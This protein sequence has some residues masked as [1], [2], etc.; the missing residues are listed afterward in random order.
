M[1]TTTTAIFRMLHLQPLLFHPYYLK[2]ENMFL[3][4]TDNLLS[5]FDMFRYDFFEGSLIV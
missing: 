1:T 2:G 4:N 3:I 5:N